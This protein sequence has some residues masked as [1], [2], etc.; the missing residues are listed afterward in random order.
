MHTENNRNGPALGLWL[1]KETAESDMRN[2]KS[3]F[4]AFAVSLFF[5]LA[6]KKTRFEDLIIKS[7]SMQINAG[8]CTFTNL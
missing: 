5:S 3:D 7:M 1:R 6:N 2:I 8:A 4:I